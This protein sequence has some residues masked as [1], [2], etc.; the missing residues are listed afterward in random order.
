MHNEEKRGGRPYPSHLLEGFHNVVSDCDL[1]DL[2]LTGH[3]FTWEK[4]KGHPNWTEIRLDRAMVN[5][6]WW[7]TFHTAQLF[8]LEI[9]LSDHNPIFM[10]LKIDQVFSNVNRFRFENAWLTD[11]K[12]LEIVK[13]NWCSNNSISIQQKLDSCK[14]ILG[15][16]GKELTRNFKERIRLC[17]REMLSLKKSTYGVSISRYKEAKRKLAKIYHQKEIYWRQRSKQLWLQ[18]GDRNTKYFHN[19]AFIRRKNNLIHQL[20]DDAGVWRDRATGLHELMETYFHTIFSTVGTDFEEVVNEI[21][22]SISEIQNDKLLEDVSH[23]KAKEAI[24]SMDPDKAPGLVGY[25]P[26]FYQKY[27]AIVGKDVTELVRTF[28]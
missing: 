7:D 6:S 25:T 8:N 23:E 1:M 28:F 17:K 10:K 14:V 13:E 15:D 9:S 19:A 21:P 27:W 22:C 11:G 20:Q 2:S 5:S 12:C 3:Q 4:S 18:C 16:W 26:G 24:F